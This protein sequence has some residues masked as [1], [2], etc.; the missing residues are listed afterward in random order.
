[1][2]K[3]VVQFVDTGIISHSTESTETQLITVPERER[4]RERKRERERERER[5]CDTKV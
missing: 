5:V 3:H 1:M 2:N 4:E